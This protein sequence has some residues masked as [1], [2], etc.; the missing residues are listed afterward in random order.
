MPGVHAQHRVRRYDEGAQVQRGAELVRD[1]VRVHLDDLLQA[2]KIDV[3]GD[4][5]DAHTRRGVVHARNVLRRAEQLDDAVGRA[6]GLQAL[7]YLLRVVQ[8]VGA[9]HELNGAV[10]DYARVVPALALVV[11][12]EEHVVRENLAEA[13]LVGRGLFLGGGGSGYF[14][15]FH[16]IVPSLRVSAGRPRLSLA[17]RLPLF[18]VTTFWRYCNR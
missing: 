11:I 15:F 14:N 17:R 6:V 7:E 9:G 10:G 16:F 1:P 8:D 5:R 13:E 18:N 12:H 3:L 4:V 2:L